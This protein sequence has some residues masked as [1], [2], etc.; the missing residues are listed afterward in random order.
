[1]KRRTWIALAAFSIFAGVRRSARSTPS[2]RP[3]SPIEDVWLA[4]YAED[5]RITLRSIVRATEAAA[6]LRSVLFPAGAT[7]F[8]PA[9]AHVF[10]EAVSWRTEPGGSCT[11][12]IDP[13]DSRDDRHIERWLEF[14]GSVELDG[15]H[16]DG[17]NRV[18]KILL[19]APK[20][21]DSIT[22]TNGSAAFARQPASQ[23]GA[24]P[25]G[26]FA[27]GIAC[28]GHF[29]R[30]TMRRFHVHHIDAAARPGVRRPNSRGVDF[31]P[32][33]HG[34]G[35]REGSPSVA[36]VRDCDVHHI[37]AGGAWGAHEIEADGIV[38][39]TIPGSAAGLAVI[40]C[41]FWSCAKRPF[42]ANAG[43]NWSLINCTF[44]EFEIG[45][46]SRF[47]SAQHGSGRILNALW[48]Y[49]A[50]DN[51]PSIALVTVSDVG[52]PAQERSTIIGGRVRLGNRE[53]IRGNRAVLHVLGESASVNV[54]DLQINV[55]G[56]LDHFCV[57]RMSARRNASEARHV[58]ARINMRRVRV[59]RINKT[60][61]HVD[62]SGTGTT[63]QRVVLEDVVVGAG[64]RDISKIT[65]IT[66]KLLID[67]V[68]STKPRRP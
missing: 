48:D 44:T 54:R 25:V 40:S 39:R 15:I 4:D 11:I 67:V 64:S 61:L 38:W 34:E 22:L 16:F 49:P 63:Y 28:R 18:N 33:A 65:A 29:E 32:A 17:S 6:G 42:K 24:V 50:S 51:W 23:D 10:R 55:P 52:Q 31:G 21:T 26:G 19:F 53:S 14:R 20:R 41:R 66:S 68:T 1:M 9:R 7:I 5:G 2:A 43:H 13:R 58:G 8:V 46:R 60:F 45:H 35:N 30:F 62:R 3:S 12:A 56:G 37:T 59:A 27:A 47:L 57:A 36:E